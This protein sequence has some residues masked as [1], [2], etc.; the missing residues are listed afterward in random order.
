MK[1][2]ILAAALAALGAGCFTV[3]RSE[4]PEVTM[5]RAP[6]GRE[7]A[8]QL[9]GF[10]ATVVSYLPVYG[11]ETV[12]REHVYRDRHGRFRDGGLYPAT[13]LTT[14]YIPQA[15]L[16][17]AFVERAQD[18]LEDAGFAVG[19]TN[20][21]YVVE[22]RFAGPVVTDGD[23]TAECLWLLCSLLS[24]DYSAQTWTARLRITEAATGR[25]LLHRDYSQKY[26]AAVWGPIPILSPAAATATDADVMQSWALSALTDRALADATQFLAGR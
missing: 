18:L 6:E 4:Y 8:V 1:R 7:I 25:L 23:R 17:P 11:H 16:T 3:H 5:S 14:T 12:W 24:G 9:A 26:V 2:I 20:A 21:A 19:L 10:E 13:Y 15:R 22:V